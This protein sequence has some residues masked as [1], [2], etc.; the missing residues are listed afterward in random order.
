[1]LDSLSE[2]KTAKIKKFAKEYIAKVI[3]KMEKRSSTSNSSSH[4]ASGSGDHSASTSRP[5]G[6][7]QPEMSVEDALDL[8]G[9][10]EDDYAQ[11]EDEDENSG[12]PSPASDVNGQGPGPAVAVVG[13]DVDADADAERDVEMDETPFVSPK[14]SR[15][16]QGPSKPGSKISADL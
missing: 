14:R 1:M 16:D 5:G 3:R 8:G 13:H 12:D 6:S 9:D 11:D 15:W 4:H 7:T 2:E 10:L